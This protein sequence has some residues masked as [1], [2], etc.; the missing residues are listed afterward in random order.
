MMPFEQ[1]IGIL[2]AYCPPAQRRGQY[3]VNLLRDVHPKANEFIKEWHELAGS[4]N[5]EAYQAYGN[6][7]YN[8]I[9]LGPFLAWVGNRWGS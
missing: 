7:F 4:D 1:Y 6:P 2:G 5:R 3:A 9:H 8:D